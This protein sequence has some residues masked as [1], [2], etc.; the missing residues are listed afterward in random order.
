MFLSAL[1]V[2]Q[3]NG[4]ENHL[5]S[6][7]DHC[8]HIVDSIVLESAGLGHEESKNLI[9][10]LQ[11][12]GPQ[13]F[14]LNEITKLTP[15]LIYKV[16]ESRL[17][18]SVIIWTLLERLINFHLENCLR[19]ENN[20]SEYVEIEELNVLQNDLPISKL[21]LSRRS[22]NALTR[23]GIHF[24]SQIR[25]LPKTKLFRM[26]NLGVA[27]VREILEELEKVGVYLENEPKSNLENILTGDVS[28]EDL[29]FS[30]RTFNALKRIGVES[31]FQLS[32]MKDH[33]LRDIRNF[34]DK[35]L[36]EVEVVLSRY[37]SYLLENNSENLHE[38]STK[39][40]DVLVW[41]ISNL[42][43]ELVEVSDKL[44]EFGHL[45]IEHT[46]IIERGSNSN[47]KDR[48]IDCQTLLDVYQKFTVESEKI[49][50]VL[51]LSEYIFALDSFISDL[52]RYF[53][54]REEVLPS[55]Y[56]KESLLKY[57]NDFSNESVDLLK[58]DD[59]SLQLL[60]LPVNN[61]TVFLGKDSYF[62][63]LDKI[64]EY[65]V[66]E[67]NV[68]NLIDGVIKFHEKY[69][70]FPNLLGL[71]IAQFM[72]SEASKG[73]DE[74][75]IVE[76]YEFIRLHISERELEILKLRIS[77][78]TL[79]EIGKVIG[80]TR[81]RVRQI[82]VKLSPNLVSVI[83]LLKK[84]NS[85]HR[86]SYLDKKIETVISNYGAVYKSELALEL[87]FS[88]EIIIDSIP[89][90]YL[91]FVIDRFPEHISSPTWT[92]ED[93]LI[94]LRKASTF[95][96]PIRQADYDHL[97]A[98]G[99]VKGPSIAYMYL[100]Y[101][102]WSELCQEAGVE[103]VPS[104]RAEY[105][106]MWSEDELLNY[107]IRFFKDPTTTGSYGS[108]DLWREEQSD[109]VPSGVLIRNV[110]GSWTNV[111]RKVLESMRKEKGLAVRYDI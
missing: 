97:L 35:C 25:E 36:A 43:M 79:D 52:L 16:S 1:R 71:I 45:K 38:K 54:N 89:K 8:S 102:Q 53:K 106:R 2:F 28:L 96:F 105:I 29:D 41:T 108:Y 88:E 60:G 101:G 70:T 37:S 87:G 77:G 17:S 80:V 26:Q 44:N 73:G 30:V 40:E 46:E 104:P 81:E 24:V 42:K 50:S 66:V 103:F 6:V 84:R 85:E 61:L 91:K 21:G 63:I 109:H 78:S 47:K 75:N 59:F 69:G 68:W 18:R 39:A 19:G 13:E 98:I 74:S 90:K 99:E 56:V 64:S 86:E 107:A 32:K 27:S 31:L 62:E 23:D 82:L 9:S 67:S 83:E 92:K 95:Y 55:K 10:C 22:M 111:K 12:D 15:Q 58:F 33:E 11:T 49:S 76:L 94:A 5:P 110:F 100:K 51:E 7:P 93:C 48:Y 3:L 20:S 14:T 34:G 72:G 57:E 4:E 65:F